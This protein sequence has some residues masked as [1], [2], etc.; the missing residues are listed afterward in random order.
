MI[1]RKSRRF[2]VLNQ[3]HSH[4]AIFIKDKV[5][6]IYYLADEFYKDFSSNHQKCKF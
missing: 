2:K 4:T 6:E 3:N 5:T 1:N